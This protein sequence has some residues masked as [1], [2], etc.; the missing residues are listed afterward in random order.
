MNCSTP[1]IVGLFRLAQKYNW[2]INKLFTK[3]RDSKFPENIPIEGDNSGT[4]YYD[5]VNKNTIQFEKLE[6][7]SMKRVNQ[8]IIL[9]YVF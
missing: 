8:Y 1:L 4:N 6:N 7:Q 9:T 5:M 2:V 3:T